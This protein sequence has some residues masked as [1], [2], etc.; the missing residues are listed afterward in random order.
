MAIFT[1]FD[2]PVGQLLAIANSTNAI[3][4]LHM[5][6]SK[7]APT[8]PPDAIDASNAAIFSTLRRQ[9]EQYFAGKRQRFELALAPAGTLFQQAVWRALLE[10]PYGETRSYGAQA[11]QIG[12]PKAV[13]A[14]GAANGRNPIGIV[15]PCHRI[16]GAQGAMTGYAAGLG[17]KE[18]LLALERQHAA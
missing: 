18:F 3:T 15:I 10:V 1:Q 16:I 11:S 9:L 12:R 14:V 6:G 2:S 17:T 5:L 7:H 4:T 8:L 13:R